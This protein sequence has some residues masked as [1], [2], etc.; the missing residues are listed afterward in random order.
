MER[1]IS[2]TPMVRAAEGPNYPVQN[3]THNLY[4]I[5]HAAD[6]LY[7]VT[8]P[9]QPVQGDGQRPGRQ[10][11]KMIAAENMMYQMWLPILNMS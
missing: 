3:R 11:A 8:T 7:T 5:S 4:H 10:T 2:T 6:I 1:G 9:V